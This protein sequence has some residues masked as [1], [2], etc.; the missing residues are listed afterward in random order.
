MLGPWRASSHSCPSRG[1]REDAAKGQWVDGA[2]TGC[3]QLNFCSDPG[4]GNQEIVSSVKLSHSP[5]ALILF[6]F[7]ILVK[8]EV[9][10]H[11]IMG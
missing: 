11:S 6:F 10:N 1:W 4:L 8:R 7:F 5:S 9:R 2:N 3:F